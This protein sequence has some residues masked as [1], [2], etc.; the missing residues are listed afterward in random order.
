MKTLTLTKEEIA[1]FE[2]NF[3]REAYEKAKVPIQQALSNAKNFRELWDSLSPHNRDIQYW[4]N[5]TVLL[6]EVELDR[7]KMETTADYVGVS[8]F[9]YW[10]DKKNKGKIR[11]VELYS[12]DSFNGEVQYYCSIN[13][14]TCEIVSIEQ[15]KW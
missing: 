7:S 12:S 1:S 2:R 11:T 9:I 14:D 6:C 3:N 13:P 15:I 5:F 8:F 4:D 10:N